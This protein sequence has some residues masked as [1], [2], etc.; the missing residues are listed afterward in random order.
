VASGEPVVR[1]HRAERQ[2]IAEAVLAEAPPLPAPADGVVRAL[3]GEV[4]HASR[5]RPVV[6]WVVSEH[7][8]LE[9]T[10][11]SVV[12]KV[13]GKGDGAAVHALLQRLHACGF[14]GEHSVPAPLGWVP[15]RRLLLQSEAPAATLYEG[16]ADPAG[17][18]HDVRR[19]GAWLARLH[20]VTGT[21]LRPLPAAFEPEKIDHYIA[22]LAALRPQ[23]G[24]RLR[25]LQSE[26][27][28][29]LRA[30]GAGPLVP[31][32]GDFQPKNVHL[33]DAQ[34]MVIDFDRAALAPA[35]RDLG[36]FIGQALTMSAAARK[37]FDDDAHA[38]ALALVDGYLAEGGSP[39]AVASVPAYV[40][41]T[42]LE[43]LFY[44]LV[45][46]PVP[47]ISFAAAWLDTCAGWLDRGS[48]EAR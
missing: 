24:W 44:R 8:A 37:S 1:T 3:G 32:H 7:S 16:L 9:T 20:A 26:L 38:W 13:Y 12:G 11:Y 25:T 23:L 41:R 18:A 48:L 42:F 2:A 5:S 17:T 19:A 31:T 35:G 21:D 46:R 4:L 45:V 47:D 40:A 43:V 22:D 14:V 30:A 27:L 29:L 39:E 34:I 6:R 10:H 33:D 15:E 36:H 28:P